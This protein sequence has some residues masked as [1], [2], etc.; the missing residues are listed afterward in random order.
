MSPAIRQ[1][2]QTYGYLIMEFPEDE[3]CTTKIN[4]TNEELTGKYLSRDG[5]QVLKQEMEG[6][7]YDILSRVFMALS[8]IKIIAAKK[9]E[10]SDGYKCVSCSYGPNNGLL[11][12]LD[13]GMFFIWKPVTYIRHSEIK[14]IEFMRMNE[15]LSIKSF[16]LLIVLN[17]NNN[18]RIT[19]TGIDKSEYK[20]IVKYILSKESIQVANKSMHLKQINSGSMNESSRKTRTR[21]NLKRSV[22]IDNQMNIDDDDDDDDDY[23]MENDKQMLEEDKHYDKQL[24]KMTRK[25]SNGI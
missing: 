1:G 15:S 8:K 11:Y 21:K 13:K 4:A 24:D 6:A 22:Q 18:Q 9:F 3:I 20:C 10:S 7:T 12:P 16:D 23:D 2:N 19:F 17:K 5:K 14:Y 25:Q